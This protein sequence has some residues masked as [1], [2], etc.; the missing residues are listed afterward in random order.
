VTGRNEGS[1]LVLVPGIQGRPEWMRPAIDALGSTHR[2]LTFS[3]SGVDAPAL[4]PAWTSRV[5]R[6]LD[7]AREETAAIVGLSFGGLV[8][9]WYAAHRP[10]RTACLVLV[11]TPS[12]RWRLDPGSARYA[13]HPRLALPFF[14]ARA[15]RRLLPE[16]ASAIPTLAGRLRFGAGYAMRALRYPLSPREMARIVREWQQTD[17]EKH[18]R[19]IRAPTLLVT[20]EE[21]LDLVVPVSSSLE[22]LTMIPGACHVTLAGTG[23]VGFLSRPRRFAEI[24]S[25]FIDA[26]ERTGQPM[27]AGREGG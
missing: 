23:H 11:S 1:L 15:V 26:Q 4:F 7:E 19:A 12:P 24:V 22:L 17:L 25:H 14:A 21:H 10:D 9:A 3:L 20:G 6:L 2:V 13:R 16:V 8:A 18:C 27:A 5:D